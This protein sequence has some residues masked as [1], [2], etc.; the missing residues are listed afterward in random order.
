MS[1][2]GRTTHALDLADPTARR[3]LHP[4][5]TMVQRR[6]LAR[7]LRMT[8]RLYEQTRREGERILTRRAE[9]LAQ[10]L[11]A[12]HIALETAHEC[13]ICFDTFEDD[14]LYRIPM[15]RCT[16]PRYLCHACVLRSLKITTHT[17]YA[18]LQCPH[19]RVWTCF[20]VESTAHTRSDVRVVIK[21][22]ELCPFTL[23]DHSTHTPHA[24]PSVLG[25]HDVRIADYVSDM[26]SSDSDRGGD[27]DEDE[28]SDEESE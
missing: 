15:C 18:A 8:Q 28:S 24:A 21:D 7:R 9:R 6:S 2:E 1:A 4:R 10:R 19:C 27:D 16:Q 23:R 26:S 13:V 14:R 5:Q 20:D 3:I 11:R 25:E 17:N 12:I 22:A